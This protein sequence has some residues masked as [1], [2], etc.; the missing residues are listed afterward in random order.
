MRARFC[1]CSLLSAT[2]TLRFI[3]GEEQSMTEKTTDPTHSIQSLAGKTI[4]KITL[5]FWFLHILITHY[6]GYFVLYFTSDRHVVIYLGLSGVKAQLHILFCFC[7]SRTFEMSCFL[8]HDK[9]LKI[10]VYDYDLLSRDE[11]VGET[12]IDLENRLLSCFSSYCGL[13]QTYCM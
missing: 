10:A 3:L 8:P 2:P 6:F 12:V 1:V 5:Q 9:D 11:K 4:R 13:P 7:V